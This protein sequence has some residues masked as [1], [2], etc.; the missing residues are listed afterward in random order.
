[1]KSH[2]DGVAFLLRQIGYTIFSNIATLGDH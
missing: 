2:S 1:M